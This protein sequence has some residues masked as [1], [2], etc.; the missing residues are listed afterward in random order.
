MRLAHLIAAAALVLAPAWA[1]IPFIPTL[2]TA[3]VI[4]PQPGPADVITIRLDG[5]LPNA[6][7]SDP[8]VEP[9]TYVTGTSVGTI[10]GITLDTVLSA[11]PCTQVL[12][13]FSK[14]VVI[15]PRLPGDYQVS[16]G[17]I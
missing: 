1:Q 11:G 12:V 6:C 15:G 4:P 10:I 3:T 9:V 8:T 7:Y 16:V 2:G 14:T 5:N 13:P 17:I